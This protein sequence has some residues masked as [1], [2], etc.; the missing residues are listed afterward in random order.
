M[1]IKSVAHWRNF[2]FV[3][4]DVL[5]ITLPQPVLLQITTRE[6]FQW[7]LGSDRPA[8]SPASTASGGIDAIRFIRNL[9]QRA[10]L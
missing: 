8:A 7:L 3:E 2:L 5:N 9:E 1:T 10:F 6:S 4:K